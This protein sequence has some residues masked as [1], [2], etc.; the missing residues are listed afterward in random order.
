MILGEH[1]LSSSTETSL[2]TAHDVAAIVAHPAYDQPRNDL[3]LLKL[4]TKVDTN[5]Y[6]PV[7]LP[8]QGVDYTGLSA[9]VIGYSSRTSV[10]KVAEV[11]FRRWGKT[12]AGKD[13]RVS[14]SDILLEVEDLLII[15]DS[16][17]VAAGVEAEWK[18][19]PDMVCAGGQ[20]G[21]DSCKVGI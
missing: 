9:T 7:C 20:V 18:I 16:D 8:Y 21:K 19:S 14:S 1:Q 6:T 2:T 5:I 12:T 17:C 15:S 4:S 11:D 3:A 13:G 10:L